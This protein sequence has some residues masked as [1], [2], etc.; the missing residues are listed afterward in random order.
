MGHARIL[1]A[2]IVASFL[3]MADAEAKDKV[4]IVYPATGPVAQAGAFAS[5][6]RNDSAR[7]SLRLEDIELSF[8]DS[9]G[10][11]VR[12]IALAESAIEIDR[13]DAIVSYGCASRNVIN[14]IGKDVIFVD[15]GGISAN[16]DILGGE[17]FGNADRLFI[18][19][20][21]DENMFRKVFSAFESLGFSR[22]EGG[23]WLGV[24]ASCASHARDSSG[25]VTGYFC[26]DSPGSDE[27]AKFVGDIA[28]SGMKVLDVDLMFIS[29]IQIVSEILHDK[30][31]YLDQSDSINIS[32][33]LGTLAIGNP[34]A[35]L[36]PSQY[37]IDVDVAETPGQREA[38]DRLL[39]GLCPDCAGSTKICGTTCP[40]T[41]NKSC[42][43]ENGKRCCNKSG[44]PVP[45]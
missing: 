15:V 4:A 13:V 3:V 41:C 16:R 17:G 14:A 34:P 38:R 35:V 5:I 26:Y 29:A 18:Q 31:R 21:Y 19:I 33:V 27:G 12:S 37:R 39:S 7:Q 36:F 44:M 24:P 2:G 9:G 28:G 20:G 42:S 40:D 45:K 11:C 23:H 6:L 1:F 8:M 30:G 43:D 25:W 32:T 10:D 22:N